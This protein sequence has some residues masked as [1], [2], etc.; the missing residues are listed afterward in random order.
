MDAQDIE[1]DKPLTPHISEDEDGGCVSDSDNYSAEPQYL[2][3]TTLFKQ[4]ETKPVLGDGLI[5]EVNGIFASLTKIEAKCIELV[6]K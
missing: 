6:N 1:I 5:L 4:P 3:S 2:E